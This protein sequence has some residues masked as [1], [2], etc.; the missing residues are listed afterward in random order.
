[1]AS[2]YGSLV[3]EACV[4][5]DK[6]R[7]GRQCL[8]DFLDD[9]SKDLQEVDALQRRFILD[10]VSGCVEHQ[11]LLDVVVKGFYIQHG[12][13]LS[14][15][16]R[17]Q[18]LMVCYLTVFAL[19]DLGLQHL[20]SIVKALDSQKMH[21]FL[22]FFFSNLTTWI[23]DEWSRVYDAAFV[24]KQWIEPLLRWR[25]EIN[26]LMD[27]LT[28]KM[29]QRGQVKKS[30]IK[31]TEPQEFCLTKPKPRHLLPE[32][33]PQQEKSK[34]VPNSTYTSPKEKQ[35]IDE[36]KQKNLQQAE[37]LLYEANINQF[38][39]ANPHKSEHTKRVMSQ[40]EED[41]QSKLKFDSRFSS[42][43]PSSKK[44]V[45]RP[46]KLN[47]AAVLRRE[48]LHER[49]LEE[50]LQSLER[51]VQGGGEPSAFLQWQQEMREKE[52]QEEQ[53]QRECRRLEARI[54][55]RKGALARQLRA[56][57][58]QKAAQLQKE[59]TAQ[60]MRSYAE[61]R[62]QEEQTLRDLVREV[63]EGHKNS[64]AAKEKIQKLKQSIV[65][66]VSEQSQGLL[67]QALEEAQAQ[68]SARFQLIRE[69]HSM[70]SLPHVRVRRFDDTETSGHGLLEEMPLAELKVRLSR[71]K[72]AQQAERQ[73]K[74]RRILEEK[75][76]QKQLQQERLE[77]IQIQ[78]RLLARAAAARREQRRAEQQASQQIPLQSQMV[79][80]LKQQLEE[81]DQEFQRLKQAERSRFRASRRTAGT[82]GTAGTQRQ[83]RTEVL[84][85]DEV[86]QS[87]ARYI[88][89]SPS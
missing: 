44:A 52:L 68:L 1:M 67:R 88:Q 17:S 26:V 29:S 31:P 66:E 49:Q 78:E 3:K 64:K 39:C 59:E 46:V 14:K 36:I 81:T 41:F 73:E 12:K 47:N 62:L 20:S 48:A 82:A 83:R 8:D 19:D 72:E 79:S 10:A 76:K 2:N 89:N 28:V 43:T 75:Q 61:K 77:N 69:I 9:A 60:L 54:S 53:P 13:C 32:I 57:Q 23:T 16:D 30:P 40:I 87:L 56:Q 65:K 6:F 7:A 33:I 80:A 50:E 34:P 5:L 38:R 27:Q 55:D 63:A 51:L 86:E 35:I 11:K 18:F 85:W 24:E 74:R 22:S 71:L 58:N 70:E 42:G 21:T 25:P 4:L 15:R 84:S 37:E 45:D